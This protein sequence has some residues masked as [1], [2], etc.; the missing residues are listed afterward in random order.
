MFEAGLQPFFV[1]ST[2]LKKYIMPFGKNSANKNAGLQTKRVKLPVAFLVVVLAVLETVS[3][4]MVFK[5]HKTPLGTLTGLMGD[6]LESDD[7]EQIKG[8]TDEQ[9]RQGYTQNDPGS[10]FWRNSQ[11]Q[12]KLVANK[13]NNNSEDKKEGSKKNKKEP[14]GKK[15]VVPPVNPANQLPTVTID[16][17][18]EGKS[19]KYGE[20]VSIAVTSTDFDGVVREL[21][22]VVNDIF[23]ESAVTSSHIFNL[24]SLPLGVY[25]IYA[26]ALDDKGGEGV[27]RTITIYV[28]PLNAFDPDI[29]EPISEPIS[30]SISSVISDTVSAIVSEPISEA[31]SEALSTDVSS[32]ISDIIST[33]VSDTISSTMSEAISNVVST[34]LSDVISD[35][36]SSVISGDISQTVSSIISGDLSSAVSAPISQILSQDLSAGISDAVSDII[37][38]VLSN[39][40]SSVVS[41]AVSTTLSNTVSEV[42]SQVVSSP[43]SVVISDTLSTP[44]SGTLSSVISDAISESLSDFLSTLLSH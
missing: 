17:G 35:A 18:L 38:D 24:E 21:S 37:S 19:F 33:P 30:D 32:I 9:K 25:K 36:I 39:E 12:T 42:I 10:W 34:P 6:K 43:I 3:F 22:L 31:I 4:A 7:R 13:D 2:C 29:S 23:N 27:S 16:L 15:K 11:S 40:I 1:N 8:E 14:K 5:T 41:D 44:V 26:K 28:D 20:T